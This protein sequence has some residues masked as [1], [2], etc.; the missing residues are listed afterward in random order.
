MSENGPVFWL[1]PP[2]PRAFSIFT[3]FVFLE[4]FQCLTWSTIEI[5]TSIAYD[6][7]MCTQ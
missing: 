5:V 6:V 2:A 7:I 3:R 4:V 1:G